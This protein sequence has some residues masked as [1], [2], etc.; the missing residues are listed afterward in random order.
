[1]IENSPA[2]R[3]FEPRPCH[4]LVATGDLRIR[5]FVTEALSRA[6]YPVDWCGGSY[7]EIL[8]SCGTKSP[9]FLIV[10]VTPEKSTGIDVVRELRVRG[11]WFPVIFLSGGP[12]KEAGALGIET[13]SKPFT[14]E[15]LKLA[16][17]RAFT[18]FSLRQLSLEAQDG[19]SP[20]LTTLRLPSGLE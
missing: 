10:D 18:R 3:W 14:L 7:R 2:M 6:D 13:L 5:S 9:L 15:M 8:Q 4:A 1:M 20:T 17:D 16:I 19:L 11:S 12:C